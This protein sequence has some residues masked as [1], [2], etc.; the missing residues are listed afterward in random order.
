M[1][2]ASAAIPVVSYA[3]IS[4]DTR[5]DEHG[6]QYQHKLNRQTAE[7]YGWTVVHEFTDNDKS[8]AKATVTRDEFEDMLRALRAGKLS[9]G[10]T[11][12]GVAV[13]ADDRL[14]RRPG[15]YERFVEAITYQDGRVYADARGPKDL[16]SEDVES[17][18]LFGAVIS[19]MEV[20]KMQRRMRNSHRARAVQGA[21]PGGTRPFGWRHDRL[22]L[23]TKE[24]GLLRAA[25]KDF[26]AGRS[27]NSIV[28]EWQRLGIVTTLGNRWTS[29]S[30][31]LTLS[32]PRLCG[33][34]E[35][36]GELVR[37]PDGNPVVGKWK[38]V[39]PP[40]EWLAIKAIFD[41]RRGRQFYPDGT[42]GQ[43]LPP[44]HREP[45]HLLTGILRCGRPGADGSLCNTPLRV[46]SHPHVKSHLYSCPA[47]S[48]G[49]CGGISRRGDFIDEFVSE[50]VL[51]KL[52]ERAMTA[53][54]VEQWAG[55]AEL[56]RQ[57]EKLSKL[58]ARWQADEISDELFFSA[59]KPLEDRI[60][61]LRADQAKHALAA[62]RL[63][64]SAA[65]DISS[66]RARW[67][68]AEEDG[69]LPLSQKRAYLR[70]ALHAVIVHPA[71]GG[72]QAFN[73]DL[74][75]LIWRE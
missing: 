15:D 50:A 28:N 10:T 6:V 2:P 37:G 26:T 47:K 41:A 14:A 18:G 36:N 31:R 16:Y 13:T 56:A 22:T 32:N 63:I 59:V 54:E 69:G 43:I 29:T 38:P 75:E 66:L 58:Q 71:G 20:R 35:I 25:A 74:L 51:A 4:A 52:E 30:L 70:E 3:R 57:R 46:N 27:L 33:W 11:V 34:R 12:Q 67:Y 21:P 65:T 7:R 8:A 23:D 72:R 73:P 48:A 55:E 60:R 24:A 44:E 1:P 49:G 19:K 40:D 39:L 64:R 61:Q 62:E 45:H 5:R 42:I 9:D 17:M 68:K 53:R